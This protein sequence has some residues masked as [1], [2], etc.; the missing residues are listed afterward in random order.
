MIKYNWVKNNVPSDEEI[1]VVGDSETDLLI[2]KQKQVHVFLVK[3]GLRD[4]DMLIK[5]SL[6][7]YSGKCSS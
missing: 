5:N 6:S 7:N 3:T 4:P 1:T 2:G